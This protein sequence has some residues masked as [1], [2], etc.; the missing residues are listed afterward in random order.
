MNHLG[1]VRVITVQPAQHS[2][3]GF[4]GQLPLQRLART[5]GI[6]GAHTIGQYLSKLT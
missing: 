5:L 4:G 3:S 6:V 1:Y 2:A